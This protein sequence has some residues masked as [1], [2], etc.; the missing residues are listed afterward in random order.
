MAGILN[1]DTP[2]SF[3][4]ELVHHYRRIGPE[5]A[6]T[7]KLD[8]VV[9]PFR[10][11]D[12]LA[13]D[14]WRVIA[15]TA[16][17]E[18]A[19]RDQ[20]IHDLRWNQFFYLLPTL[21]ILALGPILF[22]L[23]IVA[24]KQRPGRS[25]RDASPEW[26]L[27]IFLALTIFFW[28]LILFGPNSTILHQSTYVTPLL[29]FIVCTAFW[30]RLSP[31][32]TTAVVAL[33]AAATLYLYNEIPL[34]APPG[35]FTARPGLFTAGGGASMVVLTLCSLASLVALLASGVIKRPRD[36][37]VSVG[38]NASRASSGPAASSR[39]WRQFS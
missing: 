36:P 27:L 3:T 26:P 24:G 30:W 9:L 4:H 15:S 10:N 28:S 22:A 33:Q 31:L 2:H 38:S 19:R 1:I 13:R 8:N 6:I 29:A 34:D 37:L 17:G 7:N 23:S 18:H 32:V 5:K 20:A 39:A 12:E 35:L 11:E 25:L 14:A 16:K 21:G